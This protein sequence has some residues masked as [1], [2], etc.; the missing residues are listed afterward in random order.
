VNASFFLDSILGR[1]HALATRHIDAS[2]RK[3]EG[4]T[5]G[6]AQSAHALRAAS[7]EKLTEDCFTQDKAPVPSP[8][9]GQVLIRNRRRSRRC[10]AEVATGTA[11][12]FAAYI[13]AEYEKHGRLVRT[14]G[15]WPD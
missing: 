5:H 7:K 2:L 14:V 9:A 15:L 4:E 1:L 3:S 11:E 8:G 13:R 10:C 6:G 12:E